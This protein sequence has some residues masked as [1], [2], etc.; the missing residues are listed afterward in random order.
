MTEMLNLRRPQEESAQIGTCLENLK[1]KKEELLASKENTEKQGQDLLVGVAIMRLGFSSSFRMSEMRFKTWPQN[2]DI[3]SLLQRYE[4][5]ERFETP[6]SFP[7]ALKWRIWDFWDTNPILENVAKKVKDSLEKESLLHKEKVILDP[8]TAHSW[9][10]ISKD[11]RSVTMSAEPQRRPPGFYRFVHFQGVV[12]SKS[13]ESGRHCWEVEAQIDSCLEILMKE[14]EEVLTSKSNVEKQGHDL[15]GKI[16]ILRQSTVVAFIGL[17]EFLEEE[18]NRLLAPMEEMSKRIAKKRDEDIARLSQ[19]PPALEKIIQEM[20]EARN[21]PPREL[22][23]NIKGMLQRYEQKGRFVTPAPFPPAEAWSIWNLWEIYHILE[24]A[25]NTFNDT[26]TSVSPQHKGVE[27][28]FLAK[29]TSDKGSITGFKMD[30]AEG[31]VL[32]KLSNHGISSS[33]YLVYLPGIKPSPLLKD[34]IQISLDK[35]R[36]KK[37]EFLASR[38]NMEKQSECLL[39]IISVLQRCEQQEKFEIL[40]GFPPVLKWRVWESWDFHPVFEMATERFKDTLKRESQQ[41]KDEPPMEKSRRYTGSSETVP[42]IGLPNCDVLICLDCVHASC[43]IMKW[44]WAILNY[45]DCKK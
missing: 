16:E 37:E 42:G 4:Q 18:E 17:R 25:T 3:T 20:E 41:Q 6:V 24:T 30:M 2:L 11:G 21:K 7:P 31:K 26:L 14:K 13:F 38:E 28:K 22:L 19:E 36:K 15:I 34:Q 40:V 29:G 8:D 45:W 12:G 32:A 10:L 27:L 35:L 1:K 5:N 33:F 44:S 39:D 43:A 9:L 23:K